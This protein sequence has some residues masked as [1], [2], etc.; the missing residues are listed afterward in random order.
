MLRTLALTVIGCW[1]AFSVL[2]AAPAPPTI[3][4][5][6]QGTIAL[7]MGTF[8]GP[9]GAS[10]A[11]IVQSNLAMSGFFNFVP[12]ANANMTVQSNGSEGKVVDRSGG[13]VLMRSY[14]GDVTARAH[15]FA[16]DIIE[17][18]TGARGLGGS[19]IAFIAQRSGAKELFTANY[20]GTGVRQLTHDATISAA[21][22]ISPSGDR[23]AYTS[24]LKGYADIYL[25]DLS[26]GAR[27]RIVKYPGTNSG[28]AFSP[29]GRRLACT[30]S[31]D[32]NPELYT[33]N[34]SGGGALRLT[35]TPGVESSPTWS[36]DG[37]EIIYSSDNSGSPQLYRIPADGG[38]P[39]HIPTGYSYCTRPAWSPD[40]KRI[41]FNVRSGGGFQV[42][43]M[44][45]GGGSTKLVGPGSDPAWG[46]DSRHVLLVDGGKLILLNTQTGRRTQVAASIGGISEPTWTR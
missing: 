6:G 39:R 3:T 41:A 38:N 20:D 46:P 23:I 32:G 34:A 17:T 5:S 21:P 35:R 30:M 31:K 18:L 8:S 11:R 36:P 44:E 29:D 28:A 1:T 7:H 10:M 27:S 45:L 22:S 15:A 2:T 40:G 24:Y 19:K 12:A 14:S 33:M 42:A 13:N 26:S 9:D 4:I 37:T 16:N 25:V 43:V